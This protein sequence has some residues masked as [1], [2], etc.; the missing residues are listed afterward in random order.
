M[1]FAN[2]SNEVV[3]IIAITNDGPLGPPKQAKEGTLRLALKHNV[4]M[5]GMSGSSSKSWTLNTWDRLKL[6]KPFSIIYISF[7]EKYTGNKNVAVFEGEVVD[8]KIKF[9]R[10]VGVVLRDKSVFE[11]SCV[12]LTCG[13][14]LGGLIHIGQKKIRA[15]RMGEGSA[16]GITE[17]LVSFGFKTSRL[18][19]GTPPR[20][21]KKTIDWKKVG[22]QFSYESRHSK[23]ENERGIY[24]ERKDELKVSLDNTFTDFPYLKVR[25]FT[26]TLLDIHYPFKA[27]AAIPL[28]NHLPEKKY[29]N[30]GT[31]DVRIVAAISTLY[32][33]TPK[34]TCTIL[35]N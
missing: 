3:N 24:F 9:D 12:V 1:Q 34:S 35:F 13:T 5:V 17:S 11:S 26:S 29:T 16:E 7:Y 31:K 27:P 8:L 18:K 19:T 23:K 14:F 25:F 30:N 4:S 22:K 20:L 10:V 33:A 15:G 6:P 32:S 21:D 2:L 28:T